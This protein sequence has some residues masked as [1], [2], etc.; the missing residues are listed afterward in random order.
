MVK[1]ENEALKTISPIVVVKQ[2]K[3]MSLTKMKQQKR[4]Q[5][6][7]KL[8]LI[9]ESF[10]C[11]ETRRHSICSS[12]SIPQSRWKLYWMY[13]KHFIAGKENY[14]SFDW[15]VDDIRKK[16]FAILRRALQGWVNSRKVISDKTLFSE[17]RKVIKMYRLLWLDHNWDPSKHLT[18]FNS[19]VL[20]GR[21]RP[22]KKFHALYEWVEDTVN[23][24]GFIAV[25]D[26]REKASILVDTSFSKYKK[27]E[28]LGE[29][30]KGLL[31]LK[32]EGRKG[33]QKKWVPI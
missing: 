25:A 22:N 12:F 18:W 5:S 14:R 6:K 31:D 2:R 4:R 15:V 7:H 30:I 21:K 19:T 9:V 32:S 20:R 10:N 17:S 13:K 11:E 24:K 27:F 16:E 3:R 26:V 28:R 8:K 23:A 1:A 33:Q 29:R